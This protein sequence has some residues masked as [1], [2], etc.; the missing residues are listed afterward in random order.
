MCI[1]RAARAVATDGEGE[2]AETVLVTGGTGY[3]AGW[4]IVELLRRGYDVRTTVRSAAKGE[5]V[6]KAIA[7]QVDPGNRL[8]FAI[9]DL[10]SDDGWDAAAAG[11]T[12]VLHVAS[13]L[14]TTVTKSAD[15]LV[16]PAR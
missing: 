4:V 8:S 2:M 7:T 6:R 13:P 3:V 14:G 16:R 9:A 11:C 5:A 1:H 10:T 15:D 12:Y